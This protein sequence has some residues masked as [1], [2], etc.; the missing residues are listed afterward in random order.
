M[1]ALIYQGKDLRHFLA[2]LIEA[3]EKAKKVQKAKEHIAQAVNVGKTLGK[4]IHFGCCVEFVSKLFCCEI[5][6]YQVQ[7]FKFLAI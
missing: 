4:V 1:H 2:K 5:N 3:M 7:I 6:F